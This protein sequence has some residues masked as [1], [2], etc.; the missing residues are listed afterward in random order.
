[1]AAITALPPGVRVRPSELVNY[2]FTPPPLCLLPL[3]NRPSAT[4]AN[5][6]R[7]KRLEAF[8]LDGRWRGRGK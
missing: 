1:M 3:A 4:F 6:T 8:R 7:G 2:Y 5:V